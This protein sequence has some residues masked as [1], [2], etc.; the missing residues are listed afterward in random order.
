M[1]LEAITLAFM[2]ATADYLVVLDSDRRVVFANRAFRGKFL[3]GEEGT[4]L[5]FLG[6]LEA[7]SV[8]RARDALAVV[9]SSSNSRQIELYHATADGKLCPVHY[10]MGIMNIEGTKL[11][12][13]VGRNKTPDLELLGEITQLNIELED[14][15]KE[16]SEAYARLE[17]MAVIDQLTG[18]YNRHYF[19]TVVGHFF[20]DARRSLRPL[21]CM[22]I[23]VDHF[24]SINDQYGHMCGDQVLKA[25]AGRLKASSRKSDLLAR[26]GGEEFILVTPSTDI[27]TARFLAERTRSAIYREQ[28]NLGTQTITVSVSVGVSGT[29][30]MTGTLEQLIESADQALYT[31]KRDGRNRWVCYEP[32]PR[33]VKA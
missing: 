28:I 25:V 24:K 1:S 7:A 26:F 17:Q 6:L 22:M 27:K 18:L 8:E 31:A 4:G 9:E 13:A 5:D 12:A 29:E 32:P 19:F 20:E 2:N 23:D 15:Q 14:K 30:V 3:G 33:S 16:L 11:T 10:S 21:S